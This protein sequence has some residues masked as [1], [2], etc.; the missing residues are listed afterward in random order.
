MNGLYNFYQD[1]R[2]ICS[3]PNV[4]TDAGRKAILRFLAGKGASIGRMISVGAGDTPATAADTR[5][6]LEFDRANVDVSSPD[7]NE[8]KIVFKGTLNSLS[9]GRI[10]E[11]GL[12]ELVSSTNPYVTL[13]TFDRGLEAWSTGSDAS[14][15]SRLGPTSLRLE[16]ATNGSATSVLNF[17]GD[18]DSFSL[19]DVFSLA[20][21]AHD[22]NVSSLTIRFRGTDPANYFEFSPEISR[23]YNVL[24]FTKA[25]LTKTGTL[26]FSEIVSVEVKVNAKATDD[27]LDPDLFPNGLGYTGTRVDFDSITVASAALQDNSNTLISRSVL[28]GYLVK[29]ADRPVDVEYVLD[30]SI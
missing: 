4:I 2:L 21:H 19:N 18:I 16:A 24:N 22:T 27:T 15:E 23:G 7:Y 26:D 12:W 20:L 30:V 5:L 1:G 9:V 11:V 13:I 14:D 29:T 17:T 6:T 25:D 3:A 8:N 28:G 10:Y